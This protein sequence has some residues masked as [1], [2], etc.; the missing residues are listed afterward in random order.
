MKIIKKKILGSIGVLTVF[1]IVMFVL[2][3]TAQNGVK[4][5]E[6]LPQINP[7]PVYVECEEGEELKVSLL[8]EKDFQISGFQILIVNISEESKGTLRIALTDRESDILMN[9]VVPVETITPGKWVSVA[10]NVSFTAGEEYQLSIL[11]DS[12]EPYF[13]Q[14][15]EG[16][17]KNL[18]FEEKVWL[19]EEE[20]EYGISLGINQVEST[21]ITYGEIFYYSVPA[22][23]LFTVVLLLGIG[24]GFEKMLETLRKIPVGK[25][26]DRFGS[27]L[28]LVVLFGVVC[29]SIYSRAYLKGVYISAD[30]TGYMREAINLVNGNGFQYDGMAGYQSWFANWPILYPMII[31]F[32]MMITGTNAYL[33]SKLVSMLTVAVILIV[34]RI[35]FKKDAWIY[36]LCLTNIGFL[37]LCYYTWSE[38]PFILFQL[39]FAL[40]LAKILKEESSTLWSYALLGGMGLGCFLTRYYGVYVWI[41]TGIYILGLF[42]LFRKKGD[43]KL[44]Y[45]SIKLTVTA[46]VSG[47]LSVAYLF[48]NK[49]MNGMAS[50]VSRT[51]WWD[52]YRMLTNDLI[53]SLLTEFFNVFSMQIPEVIENFPYH[54]KVFVVLLIL[55]GLGWFIVRN[56]K[57]FT[58]ESVMITMA[59]MYYI[60]FICIRY[61]SSMDS[62][63]FRFFEPAT[64]LFCIGI[65]G[66]LLPYL[67]GRKAFGYFASAVTILIILAGMAIFENGGMNHEDIY[68]EAIAEQW[69][70]AYEEIPQKSVIIFNDI[71]YRASW[72]RPD[73]IDGTITPSDTLDSIRENYY[74]SE[75]LCIKAE[76]VETM[77][78]SGEYEEEVH[79]WLE[80]G[81][82]TQESEKNYVVLSLRQEAGK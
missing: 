44:F 21:K 30:S 28:F 40:T 20:L 7:D 66:L 24:F 77:L 17:G 78:E 50:G 70:E 54:L 64:F 68:Y 11:A 4:T 60:I 35:C 65:I 29:I 18:P 81:L 32:V 8:A 39:G 61:V 80:E 47:M 38:I 58:R 19:N 16:W 41:V 53:E 79:N 10:G 62:F 42:I 71:D 26:I 63:Y 22:C 69:D 52:D 37:N 1:F 2:T 6:I 45:K 34:F 57:S 9:Q 82:K 72:Y 14:V 51:M 74:G 3:R 46:F 25:W 59:V 43:R 15:P 12:S 31:A 55:V 75:Y 73:V 13:M 76:F 48:M 56:C 23:I 67:K 33:A 27:D 49:I 5:T 36:A